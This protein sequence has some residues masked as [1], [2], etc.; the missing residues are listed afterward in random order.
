MEYEDDILTILVILDDV[1][2]VVDSF[3]RS[4]KINLSIEMFLQCT[5][6]NHAVLHIH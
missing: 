3:T 2:D 4:L 6:H 1:D 5:L